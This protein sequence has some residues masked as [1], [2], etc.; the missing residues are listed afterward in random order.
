LKWVECTCILNRN[1][2]CENLPMKTITDKWKILTRRVYLRNCF[3]GTKCPTGSMK[4]T[5]QVLLYCV[6]YLRG[7]CTFTFTFRFIQQILYLK[8][9]LYVNEFGYLDFYWSFIFEHQKNIL[10]YLFLHFQQTP[11]QLWL[12]SR[13]VCSRKK[14]TAQPSMN[15][16]SFFLFLISYRKH[17]HVHITLQLH[18][19]W[20][21][22]HGTLIIK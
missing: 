7:Y 2:K 16:E 9:M 11:S 20:S 19:L 14:K 8:N 4:S 18:Y 6:I 10:N 1:P 17:K 21:K 12:K 5:K 15:Y 13:M 3:L 22:I